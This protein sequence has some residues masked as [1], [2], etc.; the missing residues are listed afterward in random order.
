[1]LWLGQ[2]VAGLATCGEAEQTLDD[3]DTLYQGSDRDPTPTSES[4]AKV[5]AA[6]DTPRCTS[7]RMS[8]AGW[9]DCFVFVLSHC[10]A[11]RLVP[12]ICSRA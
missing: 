9:C 11:N 6:L 12:T 3:L 10:I 1:M 8:G 5:A 2:V 7:R 4:L